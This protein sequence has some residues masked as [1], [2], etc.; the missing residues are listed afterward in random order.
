M[1]G[2]MASGV[3]GG[4]WFGGQS[5][6]CVQWSDGAERSFAAAGDSAGVGQWWSVGGGRGC[7]GG[8]RYGDD[9]G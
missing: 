5:G 1:R 8:A 6:W 9:A 2:V 7:G 3:G 4:A